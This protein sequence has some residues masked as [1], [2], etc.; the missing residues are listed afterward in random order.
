[1]LR[2]CEELRT[3]V[4]SH[5][6]LTRDALSTPDWYSRPTSIS[7]TTHHPLLHIAGTNNTYHINTWSQLSI[8]YND[9]SVMEQHHSALCF[10]V[11]TNPQTNIMRGLTLH[12]RSIMR[13][14]ICHAILSTDMNNHTKN[15][16][17]F[18]ARHCLPFQKGLLSDRMVRPPV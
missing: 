4:S 14:I 10:A 8:R 17:S 16:E 1:M 11:L 9:M 2:G 13:K 15:L 12:S 6:L 5:S 18:T 3:D 7:L